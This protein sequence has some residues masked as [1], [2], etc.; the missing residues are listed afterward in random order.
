[1]PDK[2]NSYFTV[3]Q[4]KTL[5]D[6]GYNHL[7]LLYIISILVIANKYGFP[8][9]TAYSKFAIN[10]IAAGKKRKEKL[11]SPTTA[12]PSYSRHPGISQPIKDLDICL[13][14]S[15]PTSPASLSAYVLPNW[16]VRELAGVG[17]LVHFLQPYGCSV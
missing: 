13:P 8:H 9:S 5:C 17:G 15:G 14:M 1:M 12:A 10:Y 16:E 6:L 4:D 2:N 11:F 7:S 3:R